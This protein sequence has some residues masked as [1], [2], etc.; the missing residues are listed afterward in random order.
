MLQIDY[1]KIAHQHN[2]KTR[3]AIVLNNVGFKMGSEQRK[4][5]GK[6]ALLGPDFLVK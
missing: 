3:K 5:Q 6:K 1:L 2:S 4:S